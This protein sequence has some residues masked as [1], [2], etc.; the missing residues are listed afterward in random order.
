M[1]NEENELKELFI[2]TAAGVIPFKGIKELRL[3]RTE[4][5]LNDFKELK[6]FHETQ[7][8]ELKTEIDPEML[9][10]VVN[11]NGEELYTEIIQLYE[12]SSFVPFVL[13][14]SMLNEIVQKHNVP[15]QFVM[16]VLE[17]MLEAEKKAKQK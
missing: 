15:W 12:I 17:N 3:E 7:T 10:N 1:N 14:N 6:G 9:C 13:F 16:G 11:K 2:K 8:V 4:G 5:E